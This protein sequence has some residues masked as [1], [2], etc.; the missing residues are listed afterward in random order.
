[1]AARL[2]R[3]QRGGGGGLMLLGRGIGDPWFKL[4]FKIH[5]ILQVYNWVYD[6]FWQSL[7]FY[8]IVQNN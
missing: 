6:H 1:M 3:R 5:I 7:T 8:S 2:N 4:W